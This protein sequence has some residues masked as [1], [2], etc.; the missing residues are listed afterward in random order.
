MAL[1]IV[2]PGDCSFYYNQ[3][4]DK[5]AGILPAKTQINTN[6]DRSEFKT[7]DG[8]TVSVGGRYIVSFS[9]TGQDGTYWVFEDMLI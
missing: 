5:S 8:Q 2:G 4:M 7:V 1:R 3:Y 9:Y 6:D